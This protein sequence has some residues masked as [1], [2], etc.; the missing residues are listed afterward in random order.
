MEAN[1]LTSLTEKGIGAKRARLY[2]TCDDN[3]SDSANLPAM[4][5]SPLKNFPDPQTGGGMNMEQI[6]RL[7]STTAASE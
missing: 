3:A 7:I 1:R 5:L 2:L 6:Q 4:N